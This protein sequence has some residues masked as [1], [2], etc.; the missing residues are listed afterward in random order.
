MTRIELLF[1]RPDLPHLGLPAPL[2]SMYGGDF[3]IARQ[4][5]FANFV[6]SV[7]GVV[8]LPVDTES[9]RI[10]SGDSEADRFVMALLRA[11]ADAV[12][13]GAN[14]FRKARGDFW[15]AAHAYSAAA[16]LFAD[17]R[18]QLG[19]PLQPRLVVVTASG[20][21]DTSQPALRGALIATT[22]AGAAHLRGS[23]PE[24]A[25]VVVFDD[26]PI[27]C[28]SLIECLHAEGLRRVLTEG[29][30][31][32]VGHL[33][34]EGLVDELFLTVS[35]VLFGRKIDDGRKSLLD[36]VDLPG[37]KLE[38]CSARRDRSHLF[39]RYALAGR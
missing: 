12:L 16:E 26:T 20:K 24:G 34:Q 9:G 31:S 32:L 11:C 29:G 28:G 15:D 3:G 23:L 4:R 5:V 27:R 38:L 33:L 1:E 13:I 36:G 14:T 25:A 30:P 17:V 39:L 2:V 22:P 21:I 7:D 35:P 18:R 10:V 6:S 37:Q 8:A 19:L